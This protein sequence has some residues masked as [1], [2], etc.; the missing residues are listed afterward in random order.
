MVTNGVLLV[1][2]FT[3]SVGAFMFGTVSRFGAPPEA[4][5]NS[6]LPAP[7]L[8]SHPA[9]AGSAFAAW[10]GFVITDNRAWAWVAV[11]LL[12]VA[13]CLGAFLFVRTGKPEHLVL[14]EER[15]EIAGDP[16]RVPYKVAEHEIPRPVIYTHGIFA[17]VTFALALLVALGVVD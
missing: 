16:V 8:L 7:A 10:L 5:R 14:A 4:I 11:G 1:W 6:R 15:D 9:L 17:A 3:M 2:L 12:A 13:I